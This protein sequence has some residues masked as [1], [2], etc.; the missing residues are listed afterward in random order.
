M[1]GLMMWTF[2][3]CWRERRQVRRRMRG[4]YRPWTGRMLHVCTLLVGSLALC[5]LACTA[6]LAD[7]GDAYLVNTAGGTLNIRSN[8]WV[9]ADVIGQLYPGD[10]VALISEGDGWSLVSA[11]IEAGQGYVKSDYLTLADTGDPLG[12]YRNTSGGRVRVR[13]E[14]DG[15]RVR[16]LEDGDTVAVTRWTDAGG[17]RWGYV[18]D[19]YVL[20]ECLQ[21]VQP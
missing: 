21:E 4:L 14:P 17:Q 2:T 19:G 12:T 5:V 7:V 18:G 6:A 11:S 1:I 10:M 15:E 3:R 9:G 13:T 16:W 8:P 20:G